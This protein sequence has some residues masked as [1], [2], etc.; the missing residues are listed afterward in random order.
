MTCHVD[1]AGHSI[2]AGAGLEYFGEASSIGLEKWRRY[3]A[4]EAES[5]LF[6]D[7]DSWE[8]DFKAQ[9]A[10]LK[11]VWIDAIAENLEVELAKGESFRVLDRYDE[12]FGDLVGVARQMHL[13]AAI[14]KVFV[15]GVTTTHPVG[16]K[17]LL[18]LLL[19]PA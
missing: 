7:D 16:A 15:A 10:R 19:T 4:K 11:Q 5:T 3:S 13:R 2:A 9:E 8:E 14:K 6:G 17:K 12:V 18:E 1:S